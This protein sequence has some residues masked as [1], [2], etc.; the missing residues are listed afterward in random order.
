MCRSSWEQP[1]LC[2]AGRDQRYEKPPTLTPYCPPHA[3]FTHTTYSAPP[4]LLHAPAARKERQAKAL[5]DIDPLKMAA[6]VL[7][8]MDLAGMKRLCMQSLART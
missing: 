1:S 3:S 5:G 4:P 7:E 6:K 2:R 8:T